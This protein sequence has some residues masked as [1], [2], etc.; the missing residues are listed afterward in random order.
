[1]IKKHTLFLLISIF[2]VACSSNFSDIKTA[3]KI[4]SDSIICDTVN[5]D[6]Y[7]Y[8][9]KTNINRFQYEINKFAEKDAI[10]KPSDSCILF[11]G[12]SSIRKWNNLETVFSPL[13]VVNRG[14]G[15]S[16]FP[17]L[18]YFADELI[19]AYNPSTIVIYEGDNDQYILNP[20]EIVEYACYLEKIIHKKLPNSTLYFLSI[21]PSPSRRDKIK[22]S[23]ET[24]KYLELL[25]DKNSNTYYINV[26]DSM[27]DDNFKLRGDIFLKDSLHLN[28]KGYEIWYEII[29]KELL[30]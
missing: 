24:N 13:P 21:K 26:W 4:Y 5:I 7:K 28:D 17:E 12:S 15:G 3:K 23:I 19:F 9:N 2:I 18:I 29:N 25:A 6:L 1:M 27:F 10:S 22:S 16:T 11:V 20:N 30:K 8:F 14:F